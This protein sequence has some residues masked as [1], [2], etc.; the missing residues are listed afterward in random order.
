MTN[1]DQQGQ[2]IS[3]GKKKNLFYKGSLQKQEAFSSIAYVDT[4]ILD[5]LRAL[6]ICLR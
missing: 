3:L 2:T 5:L 1:L 4:D 6:L